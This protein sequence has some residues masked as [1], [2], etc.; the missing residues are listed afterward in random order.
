LGGFDAFVFE[1]DFR[2]ESD[3]IWALR[4]TSRPQ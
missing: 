4:A 3:R 2:K 1:T